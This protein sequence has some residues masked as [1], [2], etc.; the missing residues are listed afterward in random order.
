MHQTLRTRLAAIQKLKPL[1]IVKRC[2]RFVGI[3]NFLS[4]FCTE[5]Q[6]LLKPMY[7]LTRKGRQLILRKEQQIVFKEIKLN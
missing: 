7:D 6:N 5:L 3:V 2:R 4:M 1:T